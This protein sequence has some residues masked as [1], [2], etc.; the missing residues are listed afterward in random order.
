MNTPPARQVSPWFA[1]CVLFGINALNF[2]DR[3]IPA[4]I[5]EPLRKEWVLN[6]STMGW[7]ST[8]FTLFYA[9]IGVPLG[10]LSD[11]WARTRLLSIG[12]AVWS[13]LTAT[14]GLTWNYWSFF[15]TRLG[16]GAGE[17][18]CAPAS[19]SMIGDLFPLHQRAR[20]LSFFML[21]LPVGVFLSFWLSGR[22]AHSYGWRAAFYIPFLP[23]VALAA[24]SL[25]IREPRRGAAEE[26]NNAGRCRAGSPYALIFGL[27]TMVWIIASGAL[28][29]FNMYA[30][31]S[32]MVAFLSR[33]HHLG[34]KEATFTAA[35]VL[36]AVGVIGLV[37]GGWLADQ[38][39][40]RRTGGRVLV[41]ALAML[42]ATPCI[43]LAIEQPPG[44]VPAF[45]L[46]MGSGSLLMFV[47]Y[48]GVY[49]AIQEVI[50]PAL[51]GTAMA[52]YFCAMYVF[53]ASF[54]PPITGWLSD[55]LARKAMAQA[56]A[57]AM[58]EQFKA[59]GLHHAMYLI[60]L[61]CLV[62]GFVLLAA[63]RAMPADVE[64]LRRWMREAEP[65]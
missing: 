4:A 16:V 45:M 64:R 29:N 2:Y 9:L 30:V 5:M 42:L 20:A 57:T 14:S 28:H 60:P 22:I 61:L 15:V 49:A 25:A 19:N 7:L 39:G 6:D 35:V 48:A 50:E 10:R 11:S 24:L 44:A 26:A 46:L 3:Q 13:L 31:N 33:Y 36:G 17:A 41:A 34:L 47:Y 65:V 56:G 55:H 8:A 27:P 53:A 37:A 40:K 43:Y 51:R 62:L 21:G 38:V 23:G 18:T 58:T 32:F 54:G 59:V 12:V 52:L 63:A 1:L